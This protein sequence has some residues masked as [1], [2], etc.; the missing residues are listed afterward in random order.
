MQYFI[1]TYG[2]QMNKSDSERISS[3]LES[4]GYKKASKVD[5]ADLVILNMCAV[6][7]SA[8]DRIYGRIKEINKMKRKK[9]KIKTLLTGCVPKKDLRKFKNHFDYVLHIKSLPRWKDFL[10]K[11]S[12][13]YY[14]DP[15]SKIF[16]EK[17]DIRYLKQE[18]LYSNNFSIFIPISTG[19]DNFCTFCIVPFVRGPLVNRSHRDIIKEARNAVKNGCK[20]IWLLGQNVNAYIS[21]TDPSINFAHLI[22]KINEIKGDF[23]IRFTSPHPKDFSDELI[24]TMAHCKKVTKYLN[25]P[26]QSGDSRILKRMNRPY[27][28]SQYKKLVKKI[29]KQIPEISLSTDVIV[30]FPGEKEKHFQ[31][32]VKLFEE[33][34]FDMAYIAQYSPR[35]GTVAAKLFKDDVK[36]TEKERRERTLTETLKKITLNKNKKY[37][38]KKVRVLIHKSK[39][40]YLIGKTNTY[41]TTK[42]KGGKKLLGKFVEVKITKATPWGLA[43]QL[44]KTPKYDK[45]LIVILG[46]TASGKTKLAI[47]LAKQFDGE[48]VSADSRQVY[49]E[50]N[51]GT[52]KPTKREIKSVPHH[53]IDIIKPNQE[54]N[55]AL[56]KDLALKTIQEIQARNKLP[57]LVGG[58]GLYISAVVENIDFPRIP[59]NKKLRKKLEKKTEKEL[60]SLYRKLDPEGSKFIEKENKRRL[61]R[62]IEVCKATGKSF[63]QQRKKDEPL[64]NVLEIGIKTDKK[65]L[66]ERIQKRIKKM[67]K[68]GLEKEVRKLFKQYKNIPS[69]D[70]IGYKEWKEYFEGKINKEAAIEKIIANTKRYAKRQMTWFKKDKKIKWIKNKKEAERLIRNFLK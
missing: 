50:M 6:R 62:A 15:R 44:E 48:I 25:L 17:F 18:P 65:I 41:K 24:S 58:T 64:F 61:I 57:F 56:Y 37:V 47:D 26:V 46:P 31:N 42:L 68:K 9:K 49:K 54:F 2:C 45:K 39:G 63:W 69:L 59:A 32:T 10:K 60:F 53:L 30:G 34:K 38:G 1:I 22:K 40:G 27:T 66:Q 3:L 52:N 12:F 36:K 13:F 29:R 33:I 4:I 23:W 70:T 8:V 5:K 7:Q 16:N 35:P 20:E 19:C 67:I 43:G 11:Q 51:I 28:I 55:V 14:P 21:P